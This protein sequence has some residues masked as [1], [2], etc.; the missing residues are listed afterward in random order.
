M[1]LSIIFLKKRF[2][3]I[4]YISSACLMLSLISFTRGDASNSKEFHVIGILFACLD[5]FGLALKPVVQEK[6]MSTDRCSE[7]EVSFYSNLMAILLITPSLI[8][9]FSEVAAGVQ[10]CVNAPN[11]LIL[12]IIQYFF[13]YVASTTELKLIKITNS[14]VFSWVTSARK[15][16]SL[17][18]SFV[19]F[20]K[21]FGFLQIQGGLL[22]FIGVSAQLFEQ[23]QKHKKTQ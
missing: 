8:L 21:P 7:F 16:I 12:L 11:S 14:F 17:C 18:S 19:L 15:V 2:S 5:M 13:G 20:S 9:Q 3:L 1:G 4:Q 10:F 23:A 6:M 22:F